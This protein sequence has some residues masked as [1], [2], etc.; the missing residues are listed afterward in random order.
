[1]CKAN[2]HVLCLLVDALFTSSVKMSDFDMA[3][4][5]ASRGEMIVVICDFNQHHRN[6]HYKEV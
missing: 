1:M 4:R 5:E 6:H 3:M 2:F